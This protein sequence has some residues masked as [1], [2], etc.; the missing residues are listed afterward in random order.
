MYGDHQLYDQS[1]DENV[2]IEVFLFELI[3]YGE[4]LFGDL[5]CC[6]VVSVQSVREIFVAVKKYFQ[7]VVGEVVVSRAPY[8]S[9]QK[10]Q[11]EKGHA[12]FRVFG[13]N[14]GDAVVFVRGID[15]NISGADV[16]ST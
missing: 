2:V 11:I 5:F 10:V 6:G 8:E 7:I 14:I 12:F 1:F 4:H 9:G 13:E 15:K 3:F 16:V